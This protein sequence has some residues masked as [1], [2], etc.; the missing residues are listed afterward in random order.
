MTPEN[1][2][3]AASSTGATSSGNVTSG[4]ASEAMIKAATAAS[5]AETPAAATPATPAAP[6]AP[7]EAPKGPQIPPAAATVQPPKPE[8]PAV[9]KPSAEAPDARITAAV[10][11]AREKTRSEVEEQYGVR[12]VNPQDAKL[13]LEMLN[14]IR[15]DPRAFIQQLQREVGSETPE[16]EEEGYPEPD[17]KSADGKLKTYSDVTLQKMLDAHARKIQK[18][19]MGEMRPV[20]DFYGKEKTAREKAER[21]ER[22][23]SRVA[24]TMDAAR[25]LPHFTPENEP[26]ILERLQAM[27]PAERRAVGPVAA[28]YMAY[29]Q[30]LAEQVFPTLQTT[31]ETTA[32]AKVRQSFA[33]KAATSQ[34][35]AHPTDSGGEGKAAKLDSVDALARHMERMAA[36]ATG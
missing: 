6:P 21:Q 31:A 10:R 25:K 23:Q 19:L 34:G 5:S 7:V 16:H 17:L 8:T 24:Q 32:E 9:A 28:L 2:N 20:M 26:L 12:G 13:A 29:S 3:V 4:T 22:I 35:Q 30:L 15:R 1:D 27:D 14:E 36:Q 33:R 18:Q 11:N